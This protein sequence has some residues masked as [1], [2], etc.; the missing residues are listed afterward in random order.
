MKQSDVEKYKAHLLK[1][2]NQ[3]LNGG[4]LKSSEDLSIAT[5]DLPDEGDIATNVISQELSFNMRQ[6][7]LHK[8]REIEG[9]LNRIEEGTFGTCEECDDE[10]KAKRLQN[11]PW[12]TL[13]ITH[14]EEKERELNKF[15]RTA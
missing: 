2:K 12:T 13:C 9:A 6:R 10:I 7:E 5:E 11:Q 1:I 14:A 3:I 4:I 15:Q 8:L